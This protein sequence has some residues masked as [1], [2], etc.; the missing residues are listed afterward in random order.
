M[1]ISNTKVTHLTP[2]SATSIT[3]LPSCLSS[4]LMLSSHLIFSLS[5][6]CFPKAF[7]T[8]LGT[9]SLSHPNYTFRLLNFAIL[10]INTIRHI[11]KKKLYYSHTIQ[12]RQISQKSYWLQTRLGD[13][14]LLQVRATTKKFQFKMGTIHFNSHLHPPKLCAIKCTTF[15]NKGAINILYKHFY[16]FVN[17]ITNIKYHKV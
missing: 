14:N 5:S 16:I 15:Q 10:T 12:N 3:F 2:S 6:G 1:Y 11:L 9:Q 8:K 17:P 13:T 4:I 7:P